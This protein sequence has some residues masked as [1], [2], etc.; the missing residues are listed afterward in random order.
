MNK[1][2]LRMLSSLAPGWGGT[3]MSGVWAS[4]VS[5]PH[6]GGSVSPP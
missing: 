2:I 6:P 3:V 5:V 4:R 1:L